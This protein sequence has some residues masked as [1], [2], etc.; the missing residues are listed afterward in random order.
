MAF[1]VSNIL[2]LKLL[3]EKQAGLLIPLTN[4][5]KE[6]VR[7]SR[8]KHWDPKFKWM[9]RAKVIKVDLP[10]FRED[11][12]SISEEEVRSRL[13]ERGILPRAPYRETSM[14][15]SCTGGVFEPYV[16][17]EGDGKV[18]PITAQGAKQKLQFLEKKS[19]TMM[20]IRKV[21]QFDEDFDSPRF[22]KEAEAIYKKMHECMVSQDLDEIQKYVTE[23]AYP[24]VTHNLESKT[25][26]WKFLENVELPYIVHARW[27]DVITKENIFCQIT[28]RFHS[29][30]CLAIYDRFGRLM[31]GSEILAKD[32]L[33]YI[34]FEKHLSNE[35]GLWRVHA[36]I[37]PDWLPPKEPA[38]IT[39][40]KP[41]EPIVE[42]IT[43]KDSVGEKVLLDEQPPKIEGKPD[44]VVSA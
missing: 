5:I 41:K 23:K 1:R 30:Q 32:V 17:P 22:L 27:T 44:N 31:H 28:V 35:Y 11:L 13:K 16:P 14:F 26:R 43:A 25:I 12:D 10:N 15:V 8:Q 19:K 20:A 37:I 2:T 40:I 38:K 3:K 33:E 36:K 24:E 21:R 39:F 29:K 34:V 42:D 7:F 4:N 6:T 18:S 9:R